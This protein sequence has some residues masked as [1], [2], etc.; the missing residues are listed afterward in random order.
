M[1]KKTSGIPETSYIVSKDNVLCKRCGVFLED[2]TFL[3]LKYVWQACSISDCGFTTFDESKL[4][5]NA[6]Q[7][8][9]YYAGANKVPA[10]LFDEKSQ[11]V[12]VFYEPPRI[13]EIK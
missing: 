3:E 4:K 2:P 11:E 9:V 10:W 7:T 13:T 6:D 5:Q 1:S 12:G 8:I